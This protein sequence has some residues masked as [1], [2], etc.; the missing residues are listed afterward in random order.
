MTPPFGKKSRKIDKT[1]SEE[2]FESWLKMKD[3]IIGGSRPVFFNQKQIKSLIKNSV[4]QL[5][6]IE[7]DSCF[8]YGLAHRSV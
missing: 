1:F 8:R 6:Q 3:N 5:E 4:V 2:M 7:K